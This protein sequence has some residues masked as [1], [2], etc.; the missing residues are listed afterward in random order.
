MRN[1]FYGKKKIQNGFFEGDGGRTHTNVLP[2]HQCY[3][4]KAI[5]VSRMRFESLHSGKVPP[6]PSWVME[7]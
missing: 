1:T 7:L 6:A 5:G 2:F 4:E 3:S